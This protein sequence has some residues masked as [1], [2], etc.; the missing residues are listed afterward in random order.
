MTFAQFKKIVTTRGYTLAQLRCET[1]PTEA[2]L[3]FMK[4]V[5]LDRFEQYVWRLENGNVSMLAA[6]RAAC[7]RMGVSV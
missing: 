7:A 3:A 1:R 4:V 6:C 2:L 5:G